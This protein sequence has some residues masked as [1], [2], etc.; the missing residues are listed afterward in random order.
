MKSLKFL[1]KNQILM[2]KTVR[3]RKRM[4]ILELLETLSEKLRIL[5]KNKVQN[6]LT[7]MS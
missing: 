5:W 7:K 2:P 6:T 1:M 3:K 4:L